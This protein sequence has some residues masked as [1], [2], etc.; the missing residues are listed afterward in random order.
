VYMVP[1]PLALS[2]VV[3]AAGAAAF[4]AGHGTL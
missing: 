2:V 1:M 3:L 4:L